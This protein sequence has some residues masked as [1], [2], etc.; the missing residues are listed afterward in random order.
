LR[1]TLQP[2]TIIDL[3]WAAGGAGAVTIAAKKAGSIIFAAIKKIL[4]ID[5]ADSLIS[6]IQYLII[7][8]YCSIKIRLYK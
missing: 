8:F 3:F 5:N 6:I 7:L 1:R 4:L 2:D